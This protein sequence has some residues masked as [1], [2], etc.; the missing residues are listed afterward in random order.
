MLK[1]HNSEDKVLELSVE[2]D[3]GSKLEWIRM[4][5]NQIRI[6][7]PYHLKVK[8]REECMGAFPFFY[9]TVVREDVPRFSILDRQL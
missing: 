8:F 4:Q 5:P 9:L 2:D 7:Y 3:R 6:M 1:L